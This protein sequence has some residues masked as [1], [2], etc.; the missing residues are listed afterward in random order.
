MNALRLAAA[1]TIATAT[2]IAAAIGCGDEILTYTDCAVPTLNEMGM[3]GGRDPCQC[4]PPP[5][6]DIMG[7]GC[8][9]DPTDQSAIDNFHACVALVHAEEDA[10]GGGGP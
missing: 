9:S 10:G 2:L 1:A 7:C 3:D 4:D 8:L 5:E 6:L